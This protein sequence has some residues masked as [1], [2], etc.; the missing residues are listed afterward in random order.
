MTIDRAVGT[1]IS[2]SVIYQFPLRFPMMKGEEKINPDALM[3][4]PTPID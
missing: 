3:L 4:V 1:S 2:A